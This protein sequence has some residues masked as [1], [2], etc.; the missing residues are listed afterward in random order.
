M[1]NQ[2]PQGAF[3]QGVQ[4]PPLTHPPQQSWIMNWSG[5]PVITGDLSLVSLIFLY[6]FPCILQSRMYFAPQRP[7]G[8]SLST[9]PLSQKAS[10]ALGISHVDAFPHPHL[11]APG[12]PSLS[13][14]LHP[15]QLRESLLVTSNHLRQVPDPDADL[16]CTAQLSPRPAFTSGIP[17]LRHSCCPGNRRRSQLQCSSQRCQSR[18]PFHLPVSKLN[19]QSFRPVISH[20]TWRFSQPLAALFYSTWKLRMRHWRARLRPPSSEPW[21]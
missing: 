9:R 10:A 3:Y 11:T 17:L 19:L 16:T 4:L 12:P 1:G 21:K 14:S 20:I 18:N 5:G 13:T 2:T 7:Q 6:F 15:R 8:P